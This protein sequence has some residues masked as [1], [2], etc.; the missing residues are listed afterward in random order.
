MKTWW[1]TQCNR[2]AVAPTKEF[3]PNCPIHGNTMVDRPDDPRRVESHAPNSDR[4]YREPKF[5]RYID[6]IKRDLII[7]RTAF[8]D[9]LFSINPIPV[10][11]NIEDADLHYEVTFGLISRGMSNSIS[12]PGPRYIWQNKLDPNWLDKFIP[13]LKNCD[14][15]IY[16]RRIGTEPNPATL[17]EIQT[18]QSFGKT[19]YVY[20]KYTSVL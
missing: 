7:E 8:L 20:E 14:F 5:S 2:F 10:I 6:D 3:I 16:A 9:N 18:L 4:N 13:A 11:S 19:I 1:C 17:Q 15:A 12:I